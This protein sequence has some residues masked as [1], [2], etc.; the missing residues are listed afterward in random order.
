MPLAIE[1][2]APR[3]VL[4]L[5]ELRADL[6]RERR[7]GRAGV[8]LSYAA[9]LRGRHEA[10][11]DLLGLLARCAGPVD[12]EWLRALPRRD[13]NTTTQT[14]AALLRD[15]LVRQRAGSHGRPMYELLSGVR[16]EVLADA[17]DGPDPWARDVVV[18]HA[19]ALGRFGLPSS[20]LETV[21]FA[22]RLGA[23]LPAAEGALELGLGLDLHE[24]SALIARTLMERSYVVRPALLGRAWQQ[25]AEPAVLGRLTDRTRLA[26]LVGVTVWADHDNQPELMMRMAEELVAEAR[27]Q[28]APGPVAQ[29]ISSALLMSA[30]HGLEY[31]ADAA[32]A[33]A[34]AQADGTPLVLATVWQH[35]GVVHDIALLRRGVD[36]ARSARHAGTLAI[37]LANLTELTL[38]RG[39][40]ECAAELGS[41]VVA[42]LAAMHLPMLKEALTACLATARALT[43]A[44]RELGAVAD[45]VEAA[46][47]HDDL[48]TSTDTLLKLACGLRACGSDEWAARAV[49][50]F[51]TQLATHDVPV[52]QEEQALL[53]HWLRD[54]AATPPSGPLD[55]ALAEVVAAARAVS[56]ARPDDVTGPPATDRNA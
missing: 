54:V 26:A 2:A 6:E 10:D 30:V 51:R 17:P 24:E 49:G 47:L 22:Q 46:W 8:G 19:G 55:Q 35:V 23:L 31:P 3:S 34:L 48:R 50:L 45:M 52:C 53:D 41:E 18:T 4:G 42:L 11:R 12:A 27:R 29:A 7:A 14:L 36:M 33:L 16:P 21:E 38:S 25:L 44:S 20:V 1:L 56:G 40:A 5:G 15:G 28:G 9:S 37:G 32:E 39:D 43:G 13:P